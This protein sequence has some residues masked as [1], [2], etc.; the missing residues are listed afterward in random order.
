MS[1]EDIVRGALVGDTD[2]LAALD[3]LVARIR[4]LEVE[5]ERLRGETDAS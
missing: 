4:E 5:N 2:R 1:N 3:A